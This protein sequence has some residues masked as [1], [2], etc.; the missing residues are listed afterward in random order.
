MILQKLQ[1]CIISQ[2]S[3]LENKS[4]EKITNAFLLFFKDPQQK[5]LPNQNSVIVHKIT[6]SIIIE[7]YK[8]S[9]N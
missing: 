2:K 1:L 9:Q 6:L 8:L 4:Y 3:H 5:R 7:K